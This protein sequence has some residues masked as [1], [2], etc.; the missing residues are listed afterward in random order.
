[1]NAW[2]APIA[3]H[4][5]TDNSTIRT[6]HIIHAQHADGAALA[7]AKTRQDPDVAAISPRKGNRSEMPVPEDID[8]HRLTMWQL[9]AR[10]PIHTIYVYTEYILDAIT[11]SLF[12]VFYR[13]FTWVT[14]FYWTMTVMSTLGFG[15]ITFHSDLGRLFSIVVLMSGI[16]FLLIILPFVFIQFFYAPWLEAQEKARPSA[17]FRKVPPTM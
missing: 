17:N 15:D 7:A 13:D 2:P 8:R 3:D 12:P 9:T 16:V 11:N 14:G 10:W 5:L 4:G 6:D 1:M